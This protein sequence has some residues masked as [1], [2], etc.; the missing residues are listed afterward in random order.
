MTIG[1][2]VRHDLNQSN[3][4]QVMLNVWLAVDRSKILDVRRNHAWFDILQP[5]PSGI[6]TCREI[7]DGPTVRRAGV[8]VA[9]VG[10]E[11]RVESHGR[12]VSSAANHRRDNRP[13]ANTG[14]ASNQ[15]HVFCP[16]RTSF[17]S[18]LSAPYHP[19]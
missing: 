5:N 18:S 12:M 10:R 16:F 19:L 1:P 8:L 17:H 3:G 2:L 11:E 4:S 9:N 15:Q 13:A 7:Y 14:F 6:C